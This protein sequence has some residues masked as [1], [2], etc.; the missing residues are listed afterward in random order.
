MTSFPIEDSAPEMPPNRGAEG[1]QSGSSPVTRARNAP[2]ADDDPRP[3]VRGTATPL[4]PGEGVAA[5]DPAGGA[6]MRTAAPSAG[7]TPALSG[8]EWREAV[9]AEQS[10][11]A[12]ERRRG[13]GRY[14]RKRAKPFGTPQAGMVRRMPSGGA[15]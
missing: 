2:D 10:R 6:R 4:L 7:T 15:A 9:K 5:P 11:Q 13:K 8:A 3:G 14:P 1:G 12:A